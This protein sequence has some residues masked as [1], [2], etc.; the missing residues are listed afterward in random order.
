MGKI[1]T[2]LNK[3]TEITHKD[4]LTVCASILGLAGIA[5]YLNDRLC[6]ARLDNIDKDYD[7][8]VLKLVFEK[9]GVDIQDVLD[10]TEDYLTGNKKL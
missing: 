6:R 9:H 3:T 7:I 8:E 5:L 4:R 10:H 2:F 1:R